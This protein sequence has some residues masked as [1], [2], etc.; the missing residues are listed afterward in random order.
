MDCA[1]VLVAGWRYEVW[2][3]DDPIRLR[4]LR[5]LAAGRRTEWV[6]KD[7]LVKVAAAGAPGMTF[8]QIEASAG[9]APSAARAALMS[10]LWFGHWRTDLSRPLSPQ[11]MIE[12][13]GVA[14]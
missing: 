11:S 9:V 8:G 14:A 1:A 5:F 6:D 7:A 13:A 12:A 10:L 4:N 2:S 3:G